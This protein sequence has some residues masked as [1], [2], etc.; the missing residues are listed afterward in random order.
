[1][2]DLLKTYENTFRKYEDKIFDNFNQ[3]SLTIK[4][5]PSLQSEISNLIEKNEKLINEQAKVVKQMD[6]ELSSLKGD[7]YE[8]FSVKVSSFKK[9]LDMNKKKLNKLSDKVDDKNAS[10]LTENNLLGENTSKKEKFLFKNKQ[11]L[12]EVQRVLISTEDMGNNI[13]VDMDG[14]T[15]GMKNVSG[16]LK[17]MNRD[18]DES[19]NVIGSMKFRKSSN[20]KI[21]LTFVI[22]LLM[23]FIG[24]ITYRIL[25]K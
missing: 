17:N 1:M 19:N 13:M 23:V 25:K 22:I 4:S 6:I 2:T 5:N 3:I 15:K 10:F 11:K 20:K 18:I 8:Q 14:Q 21:I 12:Q 16:K 9:T 24:I 7:M